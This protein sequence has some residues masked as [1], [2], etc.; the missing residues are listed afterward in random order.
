M[1]TVETKRCLMIVNC[2]G[3][4]VCAGILPDGLDVPEGLGDVAS[5]LVLNT[6]DGSLYLLAQQ[7]VV[8]TLDTSALD[9]LSAGALRRATVGKL[10][11]AELAVLG[12]PRDL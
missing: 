5:A 3:N 6:G 10:S 11:D 2:C 8:S 4:R 9:A 12:V 7:D 1:A